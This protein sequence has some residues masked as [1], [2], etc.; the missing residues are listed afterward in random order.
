MIKI[1]IKTEL[2]DIL[3]DIY[4][5]NAPKTSAHFM[6]YVDKDYYDGAAFYRSARSLDNESHRSIKIDVIEGG[7]YNDYYSDALRMEGKSNIPFDDSMSHIGVHPQIRLESTNETGV[8]HVDGALSLGRSLPDTV[9]DAFFIC[10]G[11][12]PSLDAGGM[13]HPDGLG[14]PAFGKVTSG[15]EVVRMIHNLD[16]EGQ[17]LVSDIKILS[18][19]R[20]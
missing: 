16:T 17:K 5:E 8:K 2:G 18:I 3:A 4:D 6:N 11:D 19:Q 12:Q 1:K 20:V 7:Y 13:R 10:V 14:F 15:M 9:D